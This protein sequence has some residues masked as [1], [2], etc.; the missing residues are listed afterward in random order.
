M[1][2][3]VASTLAAL[4]LLTVFASAALANDDNNTS[5]TNE[6]EI[7][8]PVY[9]GSDITSIINNQGSAGSLI[10]G[11]NNFVGFLNENNNNVTD[12]T[13][14]ITGCPI[15]QAQSKNTQKTRYIKPLNQ[16]RRNS[17]NVGSSCRKGSLSRR[18]KSIRLKTEYCNSEC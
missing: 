1:K 7:R 6:V 11:A 3:F 10:M 16:K 12:V 15:I 13:S 14:V 4:M 18:I 17:F 5:V 9:N 8:G 2:R